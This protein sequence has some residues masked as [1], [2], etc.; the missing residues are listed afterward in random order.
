ML[1]IQKIKTRYDKSKYGE[2]L[3]WLYI[4]NVLPSA[5]LGFA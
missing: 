1:Q 2:S 4:S 5:D 3:I